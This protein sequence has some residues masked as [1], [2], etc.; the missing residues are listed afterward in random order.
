MPHVERATFD[1]EA[2][3]EGMVVPLGQ[4]ASLVLDLLD[5]DVPIPVVEE[6]VP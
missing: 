2:W 4:S 1:N 5:G 6:D 3:S